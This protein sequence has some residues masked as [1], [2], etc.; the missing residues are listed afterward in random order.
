MSYQVNFKIEIASK[1]EVIETFVWDEDPRMSRGTT[2][3]V[4]P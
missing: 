2:T 4:Q 1:P 3:T